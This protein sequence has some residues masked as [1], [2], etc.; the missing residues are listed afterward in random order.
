MEQSKQMQLNLPISILEISMLK[1]IYEK[2]KNQILKSTKKSSESDLHT[3]SGRNPTKKEIASISKY[4]KIQCLA[5]HEVRLANFIIMVPSMFAFFFGT[6]DLMISL[7]HAVLTNNN[8]MG[9]I[10]ITIFVFFCFLGSFFYLI[11]ITIGG[12]SRKLRKMIKNNDYEVIDINPFGF[13]F[14]NDAMTESGPGHDTIQA[15]F[16]LNDNFYAIEAEGCPV[17]HGVIHSNYEIL[18]RFK[19]NTY[20]G[21]KTEYVY[22]VF[23]YM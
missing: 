20:F 2:E 7:K 4:K 23:A 6:C 17:K 9:Y 19:V 18:L 11:R 21:L 16:S 5:F 15:V 3:V 12:K 14:V 8:I 22:L 1:Q 10:A 13:W